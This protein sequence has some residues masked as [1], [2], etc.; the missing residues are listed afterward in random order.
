MCDIRC[1]LNAQSV[2]A[3]HTLGAHTLRRTTGLS[4]AMLASNLGFKGDGQH[5]L[6]LC[7]CSCGSLAIAASQAGTAD[8]ARDGADSIESVAAPGPCPGADRVT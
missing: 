4:S 2:H 3:A 8:V 6:S 5:V 7:S 1:D